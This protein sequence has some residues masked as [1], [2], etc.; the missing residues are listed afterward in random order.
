MVRLDLDHELPVPVADLKIRPDFPAY[1]AGLKKW[2]FRTL[3]AE[4]EEEA[5]CES[6]QQ[7]ELF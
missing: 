3:L 6:S 4:V 2:E 1:I 7:G 5:K